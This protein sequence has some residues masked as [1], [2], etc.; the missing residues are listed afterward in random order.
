[1]RGVGIKCATSDRVELPV[2]VV[3]FGAVRFA[4]AF[5][6]FRESPTVG[7]GRVVTAVGSCP[8]C[9]PPRKSRAAGVGRLG[10]DEKALALVCGSDIGRSYSRPLR[11]EPERGKVGEDVGKPKSNVPCDVLKQAESGS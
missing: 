7:V 10:E 9:P 3:G 11:I 2:F 5:R 8:R 1:V 6:E 4:V